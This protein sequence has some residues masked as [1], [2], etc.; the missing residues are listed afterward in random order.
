MKKIAFI[1]GFLCLTLHVAQAQYGSWGTDYRFGFQASP[2]FSWIKSTDKLLE[3]AGTNTGLK[4]GVLGERYFAPNYAI[5]SG[6]GFGFNHGGTVQTGYQSGVYFPDSELSSSLLDTL[7]VNS[8]L[9]YRLTYIEV[10]VGLHLRGGTNEN[11]KLKFFGE[12]PV[13]TFGFTSKA[14]GDIRGTDRQNSDDENIRE[15]VAG[16]S[17]SWGFGGGIEYEIATSATFVAGLFFQQQFTDFTGS[18]SVAAKDART[19]AITWKDEK[20]K[21]TMSFITLRMGIYF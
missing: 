10:P 8:K 18:G 20:A 19:G 6:L 12:A 9:H 4:L 17:M 1:T 2:T 21:T 7:P 5:M 13:I 3:S 14:L 16:V 11:A 15:D